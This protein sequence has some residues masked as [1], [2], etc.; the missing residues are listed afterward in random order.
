MQPQIA[1]QLCALKNGLCWDVQI[2][3]VRFAHAAHRTDQ[4]SARHPPLYS[5]TDRPTDRDRDQQPGQASVHNFWTRHA[6][7]AIHRPPPTPPSH[8][9]RPGSRKND[10][11]SRGFSSQP[12]R[13]RAATRPQVLARGRPLRQAPATSAGR[14]SPL[15]RRCLYM[16]RLPSVSGVARHGTSR[17]E[18]LLIC[19]HARRD[20]C[21][22][23]TSPQL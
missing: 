18:L 21:S 12:A 7:R 16:N 9:P 17:P 11:K 19:S 5:W 8:R 22:Y 23:G 20:G 14:V 13:A 1:A 10:R 2:G 3:R 6:A 4:H 15:P